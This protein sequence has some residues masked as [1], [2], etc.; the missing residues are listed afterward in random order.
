M[1]S[2]FWLLL[3]VLM[4]LAH[5][6]RSAPVAAQADPSSQAQ[7]YR[8]VIEEALQEFER[9]NWDEAA[10]LFAR[11]HAISPSARTLRG[12][13]LAAFEA[14]H[15]ADAIEHIS[16]ALQDERRKLPPE[17]RSELQKT[18]ARAQGFVGRLSLQVTPEQAEVQINGRS[19]RPDRDGVVLVDPGVIEVSAAADAYVSASRRVEV[20]AGE[21]LAFTLALQPTAADVSQPA[22][23]APSAPAELSIAPALAVTRPQPSDAGPSPVVPVLK[24]TF[25][26]AAAAS[27]VAGGVFLIV[28]KSEASRFK[29]DCS[30]GNGGASCDQLFDEVRSGGTWYTASIVGFSLGA[31]LAATSLVFF[32]LD[33]SAEHPATAADGCGPGA[34]G[35]GVACRF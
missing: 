28:Q 25:G 33:A 4:V 24:W 11:A 14:R 22:A 35:L 15:Y 34:T 8:S 9:G 6:A 1:R 31:A 12:M 10:A 7:Q 3:F 16:A 21:R 29:R 32:A 26:A 17:Q 2:R 13:G 18:L 27:L 19:A 23:L 20:G 5:G 30:S